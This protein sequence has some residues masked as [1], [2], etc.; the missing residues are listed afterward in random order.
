MLTSTG[1]P[2]FP[3]LSS[4]SGHTQSYSLPAGQG[5]FTQVISANQSNPLPNSSFSTPLPSSFGAA[6]VSASAA[7]ALPNY[8]ADV[9]QK[10]GISFNSGTFVQSATSLTAN[11]AASSFSHLHADFTNIGTPYLATAGSVISASG[12]LSHTAGSFVELA[13]QGTII[14]KNS[15]GQQVSA[16]SF[17][18]I[19]AFGYN[20][21]LQFSSFVAG[22]GQMTLTAPNSQGNFSLTGSELFS[23]VTLTSGMGFSVDASLTLVSDPGSLIELGPV[24]TNTGGL[25][26]IGV[27]AGS[28]VPEPTSV[29]ELGLGLLLPAG[30]WRWRRNRPRKRLHQFLVSRHAVG[31]P[32]LVAVFLVCLFPLA[33]IPAFGWNNHRRQHRPAHLRLF[34]GLQHDLDLLR[35]G[36]AASDV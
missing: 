24:G 30:T 26:N 31:A 7:V 18:M 21:L 19:A 10:S 6:T 8:G 36:P 28:T 29:V 23:N 4:A 9:N 17:T 27:F 20:N 3:T 34:H 25:P 11:A 32:L 14:I 15:S 33:A 1:S 12:F 2:L 13:E 22:T 35:L 16:D 5:A